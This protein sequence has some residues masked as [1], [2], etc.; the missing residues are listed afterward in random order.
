MDQALWLVRIAAIE[1][2][3]SPAPPAASI[4]N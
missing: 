2:G 1:I 3:T 4:V